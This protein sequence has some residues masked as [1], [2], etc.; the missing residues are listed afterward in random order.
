MTATKTRRH[1]FEVQIQMRYGWIS[2]TD[3]NFPTL[4]AAELW[5][6]E[7]MRNNPESNYQ[8]CIFDCRKGDYVN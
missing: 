4:R 2:A 6:V 8:V 3:I 1:S 5:M 7:E